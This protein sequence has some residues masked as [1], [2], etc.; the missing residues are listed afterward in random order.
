[1]ARRFEFVAWTVEEDLLDY[2]DVD[3]DEAE[4]EVSAE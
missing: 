3:Q 1:M 2:A 4:T